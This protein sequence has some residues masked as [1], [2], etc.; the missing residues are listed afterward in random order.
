MK[1]DPQTGEVVDQDNLTRY[2]VTDVATGTVPPDV[3][4]IFN[5]AKTTMDDK[6]KKALELATQRG[7]ALGAG[8]YAPFTINLKN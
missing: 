2:S 1:Y 3:V 8:R 5:D 6:Q 4:K 7:N